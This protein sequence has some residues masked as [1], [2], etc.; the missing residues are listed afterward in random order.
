MRNWKNHEALDEQILQKCAADVLK[1]LI[2]VLTRK[3]AEWAKNNTLSAKIG[4]S[5]IRLRECFDI[6]CDGLND[7]ETLCLSML[8]CLANAKQY[9]ELRLLEHVTN[10]LKYK[11]WLHDEWQMFAQLDLSIVTLLEDGC[12]DQALHAAYEGKT[13]HSKVFDKFIE[14]AMPNVSKLNQ[15]SR[16]GIVKEFEAVGTSL[17]TKPEGITAEE[18]ETELKKMLPPDFQK[19]IPKR[20]W[21]QLTESFDKVRDP[22]SLHRE[23][24]NRL[25]AR[26]SDLQERDVGKPTMEEVTE[27]LKELFG[28][29]DGCSECCPFCGMMCMKPQYHV[30]KQE[31]IHQPAGLGGARRKGSDYDGCSTPHSCVELREK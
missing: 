6:I 26:W 7:Q 25:K 23:V 3:H 5:R 12:V 16:D 20:M 22:Q 15:E 1:R 18:Y 4:A 19:T 27:K 29:T 28:A 2:S 11:K 24:T 30:G 13:H 31:T 8:S 9:C 14:D 17:K 21:S 10:T